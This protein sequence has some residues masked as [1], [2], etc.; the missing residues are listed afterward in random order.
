MITLNFTKSTELITVLCLSRVVYWQTFSITVLHY[1]LFQKLP[2]FHWF[3]FKWGQSRS[4]KQQVWLTLK[5]VVKKLENKKHHSPSNAVCSDVL[6]TLFKLT[7]AADVPSLMAS[8]HEWLY[9]YYHYSLFLKIL[10]HF[11]GLLNQF[12]ENH[13]R[14][15]TIGCCRWI[16]TSNKKARSCHSLKDIILQCAAIPKSMV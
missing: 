5:L 11:F 6:F 1:Q 7:H 2:F 15:R 13:P 4:N 14:S 16:S 12:R 8:L 3:H 10:T 9:Y